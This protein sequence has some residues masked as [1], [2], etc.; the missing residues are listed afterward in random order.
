VTAAAPPGPA[1]QAQITPRSTELLAAHKSRVYAQTSRLFAALMM[2]QWVAGIG[3]ALWLSPRTWIGGT[4]Q[5]HLHVWLAIL[6][7]GAI[8][9]LPVFLAI[10]RPAQTFTRHIVAAGQML[11]SALLIHL[12]GGRI[13]THFHIFGSLAF[14]AYYRDW[15]VLIPAT[16]VV[17]AD[18]AARGNFFPQSVFGVLT[19]SPWRWLE[20]AGWVVFEDIILVKMCLAGVREMREIAI[21]QSSIEEITQGLEQKVLERTAELERAREAAE[22]GSRAKSEF[23][24]NMSHEI[25]TPMNG[26]LGMTELALD[27]ELTSDQREYLTTAKL[28]ADSLLTV[29]NDILDFS[30]IE[31]GKLELDPIEFRLSEFVE[32]TTKMMALRAHQKGLELIC[33]IGSSAP[34]M[35]VA[36]RSRIRQILTNLIGNAVKFTDHGEV[37]LALESR[38]TK[39]TPGSPIELSFAVSDTGIFIPPEKL[40]TIFKPFA[41]ADTSTTRRYGGTGLGLTISMRLIAIMGGRLSVESQPGRGSTFRFTVLVDPATG[42][43]KAEATSPA[44]IQGVQAL[45]VDDNATNRRILS[46]TLTR[47]GMRPILAENGA[48]ALDLL[49]T[50]G[51]TCPLILTDVHMPE[52]DGFELATEV[53]RRW[54]TAVMLMLTSGS[55]TGDLARCRELGIESY[56]TKPV[57]QS[58]LQAAISRILTPHYPADSQPGTPEAAI[59]AVTPA[60]LSL[61]I[62][63]A[64]DNVVNQRVAVRLLEKEGHQVVIASDGSEA[65]AAIRRDSFHVV[66][67]DIQMPV[68]DGLEATAA[69]RDLERH[70]GEHLPI[71]AMTAHAMKGDQQ[72]CLE[73]G[74]DGYIS[75]PIRKLELLAAISRFGQVEAAQ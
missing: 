60:H 74:M 66:L 16:L 30:K 2:A 37:V 45:I 31:A 65:L 42:S 18:H 9:A 55:R 62:L 44:L 34:D 32:E 21:H 23:L 63:V 67:M 8:T 29:I 71:L 40:D 72:R 6:L 20:H 69:I 59:P 54:N 43:P 38:P 73:A 26:V 1:L 5:V 25:R 48:A 19:A 39:D 22:A 27:T 15:R 53:K 3:M 56:L 17:A 10:A 49:A 7:G 64:E 58:E 47:W 36:D 33:H 11:M 4:S 51:D 46:E 75:K 68:M 12:S 13:E 52:M 28:S 50:F 35:V 41:Q 24:A 14:L 70:T 57:A 61:R